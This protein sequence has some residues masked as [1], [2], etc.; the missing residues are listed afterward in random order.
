MPWMGNLQKPGQGGIWWPSSLWRIAQKP[1]CFFDSRS[2]GPAK[3][4]LKAHSLTKVWVIHFF[5]KAYVYLQCFLFFSSI[6]VYCGSLNL[7]GR[8][9]KYKKM[10]PNIRSFM[11][12]FASFLFFFSLHTPIPV[13][14]PTCLLPEGFPV[15]HRVEEVNIHWENHRL[16]DR[17]TALEPILTDVQ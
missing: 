10:D 13:L 16:K 3:V 12:E 4:F 11:W 1:S 6:R 2:L 8:G 5:G 15:F 7:M 17:D 14:V 9:G